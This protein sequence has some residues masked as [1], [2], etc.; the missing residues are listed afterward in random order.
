MGRAAGYAF[1][2]AQAAA[3]AIFISAC[4]PEDPARDRASDPTT[5]PVLQTDA[6]DA[7]AVAP[8]RYGTIRTRLLEGDLV[9]IDVTVENAL[10]EAV[11]LRF[12]DCAAARY[13]LIRGVRFASRVTNQVTRS[14]DTWTGAG[15]YT[16][17][18][19]DPG[20][21]SVIAARATVAGCE[22]DGIP[23]V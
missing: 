14:G 8:P 11:V 16:L 5:Y 21:T 19:A 4:T 23:T 7:P 22:A 2:G 6:D 13:A 20:S 18:R 15:V 10:S 17:W 12:G 1:A 3:C 9:A